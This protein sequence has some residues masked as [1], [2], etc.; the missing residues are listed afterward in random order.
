MRVGREQKVP[1]VNKG[2]SDPVGR[3]NLAVTTA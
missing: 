3:E 2:V 1:V